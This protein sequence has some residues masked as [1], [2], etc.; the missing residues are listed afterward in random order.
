MEKE[1]NQDGITYLSVLFAFA[2]LLLMLP[3]FTVVYS[4]IETKSYQEELE[5]NQYFRFVQDETEISS[6]IAINPS[7]LTFYYPDGTSSQFNHYEN[8][9]RK[10]TEGLGHEILLRD[11]NTIHYSVTSYGMKI[12]IKTASGKSHDKK[13]FMLQEKK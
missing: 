6:H 2:V 4:S 3:F 12:T 1:P 8:L 11:V 7:L 13:I 9:I 5:V 10:Q